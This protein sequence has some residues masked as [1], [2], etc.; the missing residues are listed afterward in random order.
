MRG[1]ETT[2][3]LSIGLVACIISWAIAVAVADAADD[4]HFDAQGR[5]QVDVQYDCQGGAPLAALS[6][7]GF[8][9]SSS[10]NIANWCVIE[11]WLPPGSLGRIASI[12]GVRR[13]QAPSYA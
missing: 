12:A 10:V 3:R 4:W 2:A 6:A 11:G 7:A 1:G 5:A 8:A 9:I 13:V